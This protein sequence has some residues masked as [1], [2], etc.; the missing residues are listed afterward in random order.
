M[1]YQLLSKLQL[2]HHPGEAVGSSS[3]SSSSSSSRGSSSSNSSSKGSSRGSSNN[4]KIMQQPK[5]TN[6]KNRYKSM[7]ES[8]SRLR[9]YI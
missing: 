4:R 6:Y 9:Q 2:P 5:L 1:T 3:S 8:D 7:L